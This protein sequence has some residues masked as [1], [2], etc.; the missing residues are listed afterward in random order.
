[1]GQ[2]FGPRSMIQDLMLFD[3]LASWISR[4]PIQCSLGIPSLPSGLG[5]VAGLLK[6]CRSQ[7]PDQ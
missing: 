3:I 5:Y 1:M 4:G 6:R 7:I 2:G